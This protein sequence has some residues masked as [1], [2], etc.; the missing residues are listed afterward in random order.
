MRL[1]K[2]ETELDR[3]LRSSRVW[4]TFITYWRGIGFLFVLVALSMIPGGILPDNHRRHGRDVSDCV[5]GN[6]HKRDMTAK[7]VLPAVA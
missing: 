4:T 3:D 1:T 6:C 5:K 7:E 2:P